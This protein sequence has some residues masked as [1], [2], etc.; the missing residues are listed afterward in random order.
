M[1]TSAAS[2][3]FLSTSAVFQN[4]AKL[5]ENVDAPGERAASWIFDWVW[6][7]A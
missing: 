6:M 1:G 4:N 2:V 5:F 3:T 7:Y